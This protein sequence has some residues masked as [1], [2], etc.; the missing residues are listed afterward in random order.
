MSHCINRRNFT[1]SVLRVCG[2]V[3]FKCNLNLRE[4][5]HSRLYDSVVKFERICGIVVKLTK[6]KSTLR[7]TAII[8]TIY[9]NRMII[10][11][12]CIH[13]HLSLEVITIKLLIYKTIHDA[14]LQ[15]RT[16][17]M[18]SPLDFTKY[19]SAIRNKSF[20]T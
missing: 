10:L 19:C 17:G 7:C 1:H 18:A 8:I 6:L 13:E 16:D 15:L 12:I 9:C 4:I 20:I 3:T 2:D 14:K 5:A 11:Q